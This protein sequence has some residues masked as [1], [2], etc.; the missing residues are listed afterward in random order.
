MLLS[1]KF[2]YWLVRLHPCSIW[3]VDDVA[4]VEDIVTVSEPD[5][6]RSVEA[7]EMVSASEFGWLDEVELGLKE[8]Y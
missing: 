6:S 8:K 1:N 2:W 3:K 7:M 5:L 4:D